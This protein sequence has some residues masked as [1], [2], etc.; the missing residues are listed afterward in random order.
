MG[1][2]DSLEPSYQDPL[3][4]LSLVTVT[5]TNLL[6]DYLKPKALRIKVPPGLIVIYLR[7]SVFCWP[8]ENP[9]LIPAS[10][11]SGDDEFLHLNTPNYVWTVFLVVMSF[12]PRRMVE[13]VKMY[14]KS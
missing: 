14:L 4:S 10:R 3:P 1:S 6:L 5:E 8:F 7:H 9:R 2:G 13:Q 11:A 12:H